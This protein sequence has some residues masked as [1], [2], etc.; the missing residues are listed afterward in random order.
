MHKHARVKLI[1][2]T[3]ACLCIKYLMDTAFI[4]ISNIAF[5]IAFASVYSIF[6]CVFFLFN[7]KHNNSS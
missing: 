4:A 3:H 2:L 5:D 6:L 7:Q 1:S